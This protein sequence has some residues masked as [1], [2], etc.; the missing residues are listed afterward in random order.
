MKVT[1][2]N[3]LEHQEEIVSLFTE[4]TQMLVDTDPSF[5]AYLTLQNYEHEIADLPYKYGA[6][7]GGVLRLALVDGKPAGC[8]GLRKLDD[9]RCEMKRL[10]VRPAYRKQ[11]LGDQLVQQILQ[12]AKAMGYKQM[13]LDTLPQLDSAVRLYQRHGFDFI[14]CYNDS[15]VDTTLF[16]GKDL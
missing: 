5:A 11:K 4:Y 15:P 8:I 14:P 13:L 3:G 9:A 1:F 12:D 10:Y 16:M 7:V 2:V 6:Q